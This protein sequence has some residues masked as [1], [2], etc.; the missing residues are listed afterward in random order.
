M[1]DNLNPESG[2]L[3]R[4]EPA[5]AARA[6][7]TPGE[8]MDREIALGGGGAPAMAVHQWLDGEAAESAAR[9]AASSDA[10]LWAKIT[11][12]TARRGRMTTPAPV[13]NRLMAAIPDTAPAPTA[14]APQPWF[15]RQISLG[16]P[17][18]AAAGAGLLAVGA[19]LGA[20]LF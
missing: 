13:L 11:E 14:V 8:S 12:E 10:E 5:A 4:S 20:L 18:L 2:D 16:V 9:R 6:R 3:G 15:Q 17:A 19:M 7:V 1:V